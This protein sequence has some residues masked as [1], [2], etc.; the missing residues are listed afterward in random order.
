M[1][2]Y[3]NGRFNVTAADGR[4]IGHIDGD[5]FIRDSQARLMYRIDGNEVYKMDGGFLGELDSG[6]LRVQGEVFFRISNE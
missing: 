5:E 6:V 4:L 2:N 3:E 1:K